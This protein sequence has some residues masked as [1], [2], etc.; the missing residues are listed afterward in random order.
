MHDN[1]LRPPTMTRQ[2]LDALPVL[3]TSRDVIKLTG[4]T[5]RAI[6]GLARAG[7]LPCKK[8]GNRYLFNTAA[9]LELCGLGGGCSAA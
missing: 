9:I 5:D 1:H 6:Q 7:K 2:E 4:M 3:I 8:M